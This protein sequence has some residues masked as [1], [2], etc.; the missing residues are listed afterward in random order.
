MQTTRARSD[1]GRDDR[2]AGLD[3]PVRLELRLLG[4]IDVVGLERPLTSQQL[5]LVTYLACVGPAGREALVDALWDGA[6]VSDDRFA[7]L[8]SAV[9]VQVGRNRLPPAEAGRYRLVG[10]PT[11]LDL[12]VAALAD[13]EGG[14]RGGA[15]DDGLARLD[16]AIGRL[17]GPVCD[18]PGPR[19]WSWLD[20]HP[21]VS[22]GAEAMVARAAGRLVGV[23][24]H[25]GDLE[26]AQEVCERALACVPLDRDLTLALG[27]LH[28]AQGRPGTAHRLLARW[29]HELQRLDGAAV[30]AVHRPESSDPPGR[31]GS[32]PIEAAGG[33]RRP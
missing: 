11:D 25:R 18:R 16:A 31:A 21:E 7:N 9:R 19:Y 5:S 8:V 26:R 6:V 14:G 29:H 28:R 33:G 1:R 10:L 23:L 12:L 2:S 17:G 30:E 32:H 13:G 15:G 4:P 27:S 20:R 24:R 22:A 3:S